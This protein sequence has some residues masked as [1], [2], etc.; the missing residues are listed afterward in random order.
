MTKAVL[1]SIRPRWCGLIANGTK[2]VEVRKSR[3]KIATPFKCYIYCTKDQRLTFFRGKRYCYADDHAH[4]AFDIPCNGAVIGE[5]ECYDIVH[6]LR[7]GGIGGIVRYGIYLPDW[8]V[9]TADGIFDDACLPRDEAEAYLGGR[10]GWAWRISGLRIY[11][12]P[13][14]LSP[15]RR[16]Y[17]C[18]DCDAK[19]WATD[20]NACHD[21]GKIKRP[22][23][24]WRYVEELSDEQTP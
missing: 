2:T 22:P 5:F 24:S 13:R 8:S 12:K 4:N 23:Q 7:F 15:L 21:K 14:A 19:L 10:D 6:L 17:E 3:P 1:I 11:D 9:V 20:C 18:D 16:P